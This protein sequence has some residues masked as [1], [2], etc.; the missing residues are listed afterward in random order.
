MNKITFQTGNNPKLLR[1]I[2]G[3]LKFI[4][5]SLFKTSDFFM[6]LINLDS[7]NFL[8]FLV[9]KWWGLLLPFVFWWPCG[10]KGWNI[11]LISPS[12]SMS[13]STIIYDMAECISFLSN[14][15]TEEK[16]TPPCCSGFKS[17]LKTNAEC[18]CEA[19]KSSI[20]VNLTRAATLPSACQVSAPIS[21]C[22]GKY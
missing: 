17:V 6:S 19:L 18:I 21:K 3:N 4:C 7:P 22:N 20:D 1:E 13:C 12:P 11:T 2:Q 10:G 9:R 5:I 14:G 15:S 16:A 8:I